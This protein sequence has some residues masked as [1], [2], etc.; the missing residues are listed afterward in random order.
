MPVSREAMKKIRTRTEQT[1]RFEVA[2]RDYVADHRVAVDFVNRHSSIVEDWRG[3][4]D[5]GSEDT[6]R[7]LVDRLVEHLADRI[8]PHTD[9]NG[10][11]L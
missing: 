2:Y 11:R 4:L 6:I 10:H 9:G 7:P 1:D 5:D 8:A 3:V